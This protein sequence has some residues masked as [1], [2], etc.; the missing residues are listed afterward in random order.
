M[1]DNLITLT[2]IEALPETIVSVI[3]VNEGKDAKSVADSWSGGTAVVVANALQSLA[4]RD[5][6]GQEVVRL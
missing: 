3:E 2:D 4:A 6:A 5:N 1:P